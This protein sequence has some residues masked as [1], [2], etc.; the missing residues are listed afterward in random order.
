MVSDLDVILRWEQFGAQWEVLQRTP[1][2]VV[3]ALRRCDGGEEV[4]RLVSTEPALLDH[5]DR[6]L[7]GG[8]PSR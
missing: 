6:H 5:V 8:A 4:S 2:R 3:L 1:D 7:D